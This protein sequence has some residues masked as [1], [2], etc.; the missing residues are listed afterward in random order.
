MLN[1]ICDAKQQTPPQHDAVLSGDP[2]PPSE[3]QMRSSVTPPLRCTLMHAHTR[4]L[5]DQS[6]R[7][8]HLT[9]CF[10]SLN[11][12]SCVFVEL[13]VKSHLMWIFCECVCVYVYVCVCVHIYM[14]LCLFIH[15][16][17]HTCMQSQARLRG[18]WT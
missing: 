10:F 12:S 11:T 13:K 8:T 2:R 7:Q 1:E 3:G 6:K 5:I 4:M 15:I 9:Q 18:G 16:Y 14:F 17:T